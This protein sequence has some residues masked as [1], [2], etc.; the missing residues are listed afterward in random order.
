[1]PNTSELDLCRVIWCSYLI[2]CLTE[3]QSSVKGSGGTFSYR[4][5]SVGLHGSAIW[6]RNARGDDEKRRPQQ[7]EEHKFVEVKRRHVVRGVH[8]CCDLTTQIH[9]AHETLLSDPWTDMSY[10]LV[11]S[12]RAWPLFTEPRSKLRCVFIAPP[13]SDITAAKWGWCS[14]LWGRRETRGLPPPSTLPINN[15]HHSAKL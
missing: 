4:S 12:H 8:W 6:R 14:A 7:Q 3:T 1:M 13:L 11:T 9:T 10:R 5:L 2:K 15:Q